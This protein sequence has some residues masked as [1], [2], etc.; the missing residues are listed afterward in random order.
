MRTVDSEPKHIKLCL[1]ARRLYERA[2]GGLSW[3]AWGVLSRFHGWWGR[4][5][6]LA[7]GQVASARQHDYATRYE[8]QRIMSTIDMY[9]DGA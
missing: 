8:T 2:S 6:S 7:D 9:F 5:E 3:V 1:P 4:P